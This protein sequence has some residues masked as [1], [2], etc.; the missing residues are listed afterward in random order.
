MTKHA[1]TPN[2]PARSEH[3]EEPD[4]IVDIYP[5]F[6][7]SLTVT[8]VTTETLPV[9]PERRT[10]LAPSY[11]QLAKDLILKPD[12]IRTN[13]FADF[14][15]APKRRPKANVVFGKS[16]SGNTFNGGP[17]TRNMFL[18]RGNRDV[19]DAI[20]KDHMNCKDLNYMYIKIMSK[21]EA[22]LTRF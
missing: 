2:V 11:R 6:T 13:D 7:P 5:P 3:G 10:G 21:A 19:S 4:T 1:E 22:I 20:V 9:S 8:A 12:G 15:P 17:T 18:F 14:Q 16:I